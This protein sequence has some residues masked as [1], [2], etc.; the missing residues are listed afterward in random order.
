MN[1]GLHDAFRLVPRLLRVLDGADQGL[2][3]DYTRE[4]RPVARE[5]ILAQADANRSRMQERDAARRL[6]SLRELQAV[7]AD[8]VRARDYLLRTSMITGLRAARVAA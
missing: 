3:D 1:G 8:P 4:R 7:A 2:L 6:A 5:Q